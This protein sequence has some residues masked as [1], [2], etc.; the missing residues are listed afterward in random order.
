M[1]AYANGCKDNWD[2]QL[3]LAVF[4]INNAASTLGDRDGLTAFFIDRSAHPRL[5]LS[6]PAILGSDPPGPYLRQMREV[7]L[8]VR[9]L[10]SAAQQER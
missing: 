9:E 10:L 4:A 8:T 3:P 7:E 1:R 6:A 5:Q 2:L